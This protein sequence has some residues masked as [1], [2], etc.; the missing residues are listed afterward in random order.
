MRRRD[1]SLVGEGIHDARRRDVDQREAV[2]RAVLHLIGRTR[3]RDGERPGSRL[4]GR[5]HD[6]EVL[7]RSKTVPAQ[8]D[9]EVLGAVQTV[10]ERHRVVAQIDRRARAVEELHELPRVVPDI[11]VVDL[12]DDDVRG[13]DATARGLDRT[14]DEGRRA[15]EDEKRPLGHAAKLETATARRKGLFANCFALVTQLFH[16]AQSATR[17]RQIRSCD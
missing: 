9:T 3:K 8:R 12:V 4:H 14:A 13:L 17:G 2:R 16:S 1:R 15:E 10:H 6:H 11:V 7:T 5:I